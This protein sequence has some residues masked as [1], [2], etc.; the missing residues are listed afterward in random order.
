MVSGRCV[1]GHCGATGR[2][3]HLLSLVKRMSQLSWRQI[4]FHYEV[5][6]GEREMKKSEETRFSSVLLLLS[7]VIKVLKGPCQLRVWVGK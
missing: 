2:D 4:F 7:V 6:R 1:Q 3:N 5:E